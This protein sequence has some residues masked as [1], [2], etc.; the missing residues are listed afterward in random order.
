MKN[1][2]ITI[3]LSCMVSI[4]WRCEVQLLIGLFLLSH[5]FCFYCLYGDSNLD[6]CDIFPIAQTFLSFCFF[7]KIIQN[8]AWF[9]AGLLSYFAIT[10]FIMSINSG[11]LLKVTRTS[12]DLCYFGLFGCFYLTDAISSLLFFIDDE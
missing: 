9:F 2:L 12:T 4:S 11:L 5:F 8:L 10:C 1:S 3:L 7:I 6:N